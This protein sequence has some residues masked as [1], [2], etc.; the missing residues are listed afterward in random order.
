VAEQNPENPTAVQRAFA[1]RD[2]LVERYRPYVY[3][4]AKQVSSSFPVRIDF[5]ELVG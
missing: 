3:S 5:E 4:I 1:D 2:E